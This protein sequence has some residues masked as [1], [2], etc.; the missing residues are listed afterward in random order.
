[1][2]SETGVLTNTTIGIQSMHL[3]YSADGNP[4]VYKPVAVSG[5]VNAPA[6]YHQTADGGADIGMTTATTVKRKRGR[7]RKYAPDGNM[8]LALISPPLN[9]SAPPAAAVGGGFP[10]GGGT[11]Q[12]SPSQ[13]PATI[14]HPPSSSSM[15]K[16][17]G[18]P[19]GSGKKNQHQLNNNLGST[20]IGFTPHVITVKAGE[21]LIQMSSQDVASRIMS[22]SQHGPRAVCILSAN[23]AISNVTLRQP[24]MSGGTVTY[25]GRFEI[26]SLS[27]SFMLSESA[28]HRS[29]IGGL[30]VSLAGPDGCVLGGGVAGLLTAASP[31][32][33]VVGSF[34]AEERQ[35]SRLSHQMDPLPG[36]Q[37][38]ISGVGLARHSSPPSRGTPSDTSGGAGSP[39]NQSMGVGDFRLSDCRSASLSSSSKMEIRIDLTSQYVRVTTRLKVEN[40]GNDPVSDFLLALPDHQSKNL[41]YLS[42]AQ[43]EGKGKTKSNTISLPVQL[44]EPAGMPPGLTFFSASLQKELAKGKVVSLE[45][46][47]DSACYLSPYAVETQTLTIKLPDGRIE[48]YTKLDNTKTHGSEIKYGPYENLP[49]FKYSPIVV[50][51]ED[52]K[53][54]AVAQKLVREIEISHWG[55][56]QVT[57]H[58]HLTNRGAR[59]KGEFS[60]LD[61]Q[62]QPQNKGTRFLNISFG[63]PVKDLVVEEFILEVVL[64]EGSRYTSVSVPFSV[65]ESQETKQSHLDIIGRPVVILEK[66]NVVPD[67]NQHF[68]IIHP[69]GSVLV[70]NVTRD[71]YKVSQQQDVYY[72][73]SNISLLREPLMLISGFFFFFIACILYVHT[74]VT[75]SKSS[76]S[77]FARLQLDEVRTAVQQ[78]QNIIH[79]CIAIHEKLEASLHELSRTGNVQTCK[80]ARKSADSLLKELSKDLKPLLASLHSNP[81][82]AQILPKVEELATKERELQERIM[83]KHAIVV[84][85]FEK[86]LGGREIENRIAPHQQKIISLK[87]EEN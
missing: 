50:H 68:Q 83:S 85:C 73:F 63:S 3:G 12:F 66:N 9:A 81:Q 46:L 18:R 55:S 31:V 13:A 64:P 60:R 30:S 62:S 77:Y 76:A 41:A 5:A 6:I 40:R 24:A 74:D 49:S 27:G 52:N 56:I 7:P 23:G 22:F 15:K 61:F 42:V 2:S 57:E 14:H 35:E 38:L 37:Q 75:I 32:Q 1:M 36:P 25:E 79:Q 16:G 72:K 17:R 58:Y 28:G 84:D 8:G 29:R 67:H 10:G 19:P 39:M 82:A 4:S 33:V 54:F 78:L 11:L 43:S 20:G 53:P 51:F 87:L 86:K 71:M 80:A 70:V 21:I 34:M 44:A 45:V 65:K 59:L 69:L 48:S 26:L 47:G